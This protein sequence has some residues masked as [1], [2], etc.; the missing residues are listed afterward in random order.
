MRRLSY[1]LTVL[2]LMFLSGWPAVAADYDWELMDTRDGI[3]T[4][5]KE[6]EGTDVCRF[7]AIAF[8]DAPMAVI[9]A[10]LSD[11]E[12]Y[13]QWVPQCRQV[14]EL[15]SDGERDKILYFQMDSPFPYKSRDMVVENTSEYQLD[16]GYVKI[17]FQLSE[18]MEVPVP[19][20][21]V[22][23]PHMNGYYRFEYFGPGKTRMTYCYEGDPGGNV[24]VSL[25]NRL[26]I[27]KYPYMNIAGMRRM[28]KKD[29]YVQVGRDLP[30]HA[31][32]KAI[33]EE[34][35][36]LAGII[37]SHAGRYITDP[38]LLEILYLES[39]EATFPEK[40]AQPE[41][42]RED[43]KLSRVQKEIIRM[44][45]ALI[46]SPAAGDYLRDR[47]L[48]AFFSVKEVRYHRWLKEALAREETLLNLFLDN[49][50]GL[51]KKVL[52]SPAAVAALVENQEDMDII[53]NCSDPGDI[54]AADEEVA[55]KI[56]DHLKDGDAL[57]KIGATVAGAIR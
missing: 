11:V 21:F 32:I 7:K 5:K 35:D 39:R 3:A 36:G 20:K 46:N 29:K 16:K 45:S 43:G 28:V 54:I 44:L 26:E 50:N 15:R 34:E 47:P 24:P 10:V 12:N 40:P 18:K 17:S 55:E 9:G 30:D 48:D 2:L 27:K 4:Y 41:Q 52:R 49:K 23:L 22:R 14:K 56:K 33:V 8:V 57:T 25:A 42:E 19:D 38:A 51:L 37:K 13:P 6:L 53:L 1:G 31:R